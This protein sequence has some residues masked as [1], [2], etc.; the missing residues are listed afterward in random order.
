[1][2]EKRDAAMESV[3]A[4]QHV[5]DDANALASGSDARKA[6]IMAD[7]KRLVLASAFTNVYQ[8]PK[9]GQDYKELPA[10]RN[11]EG[12][13]SPWYMW[14]A[15][16][17]KGAKGE[18]MAEDNELG[19]QGAAANGLAEV[20]TA[21]QDD[22]DQQ[23]VGEHAGHDEE[24][25]TGGDEIIEENS[26][27]Q[28]NPPSPED[29]PDIDDALDAEEETDEAQEL[30]GELG[31]ALAGEDPAQTTPVEVLQVNHDVSR[32]FVGCGAARRGRAGAQGAAAPYRGLRHGPLTWLFLFLFSLLVGPSFSFANF[33]VVVAGPG[34]GDWRQQPL[35]SGSC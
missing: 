18:N 29:D 23:H 32:V 20:I 22:N 8:E 10:F 14:G 6:E 25:V 35:Y 31:D 12:W 34:P 5:I 24:Y 9:D 19:E 13:I 15:V 3:A 4:V 21:L 33:G 27:G 28:C 30:A 17:G 2:R 7:P 11:P 16:V 1:M 26:A